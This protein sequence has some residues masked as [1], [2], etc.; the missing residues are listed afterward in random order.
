MNSSC[1]LA[2]VI[3]T[4]AENESNRPIISPEERRTKEADLETVPATEKDTN[5]KK[6]HQGLR[7]L[8]AALTSWIS[9]QELQAVW[10]NELYQLIFAN[11]SFFPRKTP[12]VIFIISVHPGLEDRPVGFWPERF[13]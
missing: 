8:F 2:S 9:S 3:D 11:G 6:N 1:Y 7:L 4:R 5:C 13:L 12:N 10:E